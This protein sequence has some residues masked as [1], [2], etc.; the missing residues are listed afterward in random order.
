MF[1]SDREKLS[2]PPSD[3]RPADL[4]LYRMSAGGGKATQLTTPQLWT[5]GDTDPVWRPRS[6]QVLFIRWHR[7]PP[8]NQPYSQLALL[9][10]RS[11]HETA[12]TQMGGRVVQPAWDPKGQRVAFVRRTDGSN[13]IVVT[14]LTK[15]RGVA[16]LGPRTL[17]AQGEVAQP[18]F[19]PNGRW[20][21]FLRADGDGF[22]LYLERSQGGRPM[23]VSSISNGIDARWRPVW[24]R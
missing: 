15:R 3:L 24:L 11:R 2:S 7:L 13:Q 1:S 17:I 18:A 4:A 19:S 6:R 5:G 9:D 20:I 23:K 12:L 22:S 8:T 16:Q 10:T 14:K 21:S